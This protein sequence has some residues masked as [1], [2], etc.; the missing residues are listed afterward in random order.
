MPH[1][2]VSLLL[3]LMLCYIGLLYTHLN[4]ACALFPLAACGVVFTSVDVVCLLPY[5]YICH[6]CEEWGE[7]SVI[8]CNSSNMRLCVSILVSFICRFFLLI[9]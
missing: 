4:L 6:G 5:L 2:N 7:Y 8:L 1:V 9:L 3:L